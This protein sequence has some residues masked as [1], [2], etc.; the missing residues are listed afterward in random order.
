MTASSA[1]PTSAKVTVE[2]PVRDP[3]STLPKSVTSP[4][5]L[6]P[7]PLPT[8]SRANRLARII[9]G[10]RNSVTTR[11]PDWKLCGS[12]SV[13]A[14]EACSAS[15][16]RGVKAPVLGRSARTSSAPSGTPSTRATF[17]SAGAA[18]AA[19]AAGLVPRRSAA[20]CAERSCSTTVLSSSRKVAWSTRPAVVR[21]LTWSSD[22]SRPSG[23]L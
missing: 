9:T 1:P 12:T 18:G 4:I 13:A 11:T 19:P 2:P 8:N 15:D 16:S 20:S 3:S 7:P 10:S 5:A 23:S 22:T 14:P 21:A 6:L 17:G